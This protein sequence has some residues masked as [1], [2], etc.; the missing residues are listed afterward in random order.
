MHEC[1]D[2]EIQDLP[3]LYLILMYQLNRKSFYRPNLQLLPSMLEDFNHDNKDPSIIHYQSNL[4]E[5]LMEH[6]LYTTLCHSSFKITNFYSI[7]KF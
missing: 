5:P 7:T 4:N 6:L 2:H 1:Q 3:L